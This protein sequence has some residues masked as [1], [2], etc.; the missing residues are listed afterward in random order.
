MFLGGI[1][2]NK[3]LKWVSVLNMVK[4]DDDTKTRLIDVILK[5][6]FKLTQQIIPR[7]C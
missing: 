3:W 1:E 7:F 4:A 6:N 5:V 2:R